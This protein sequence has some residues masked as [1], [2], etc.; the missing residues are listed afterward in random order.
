MAAFVKYAQPVSKKSIK[1][2]QPAA[3]TEEKKLSNHAQRRLDERK[4]GAILVSL[5]PMCAYR[6]RFRRGQD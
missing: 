6:F 1:S 3:E 4:K 2:Q 5:F